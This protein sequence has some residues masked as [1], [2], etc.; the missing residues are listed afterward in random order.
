MGNSDQASQTAN[1]S[2]RSGI[3]PMRVKIVTNFSE[4]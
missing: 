2:R 4:D 1:S 3:P